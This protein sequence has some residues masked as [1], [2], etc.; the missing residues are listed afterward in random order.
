MINRNNIIS[1]VT[2]YRLDVPLIKPYK[3]QMDTCQF[4]QQKLENIL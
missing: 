3:L 1:K 2:I 4:F